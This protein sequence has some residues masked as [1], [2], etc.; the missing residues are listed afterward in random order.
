MA[1]PSG[2]AMKEKF[3]TWKREDFWKDKH[4]TTSPT[5]PDWKAV[6]RRTVYDLDTDALI[7]DVQVNHDVDE[8]EYQYDISALDTDKPGVRNTKTVLKYRSVGAPDVSEVYSPPRVA[9][10]AARR[11]LR[12]GFSLDLNVIWSDGQPWDLSV[13]GTELRW[14]R[15][16]SMRNP[17]CS[18]EALPALCSA[19]C[20]TET[21]IVILQPHGQR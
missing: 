4:V 21:A 3:R 18:S 1:K 19:Y 5:G 14:F 10:E 13:K 2:V 12:P 16:C 20:R 8:S 11:G 17:L 15:Q 9:A 7:E 6:I